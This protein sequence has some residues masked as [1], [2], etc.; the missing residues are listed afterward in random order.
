ME[1]NGFTLELDEVTRLVFNK[2]VNILST[3]V[4]ADLIRAIG[5]LNESEDIK[6][7]VIAATGPTFLAGADIKEMSTMDE[8]G[9]RRFAEHIHSAM[10][11]LEGLSKPVIAEVQGFCLGG[12]CE[13]LLATDLAVASEAAV[14]GQP[15]VDLGIIPGAGATQRLKKRI[16]L[17]KAK[18]LIYTGRKVSAMEAAQMGLINSVAAPGR[19]SVEVME[20]AGLIAAKPMQCLR[21]A[22]RLL[23]DGSLE[24]EIDSFVEMFGYGDQSVLMKSFLSRSKK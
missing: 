20:L 5:L 18:E 12:G 11:A 13:L 3:P 21:E 16:G 15:E 7:L 2:P 19:L 9:A 10:N 6:V 14:F 23:N 17:L 24:E 4:V 8:A 1:F 22:K